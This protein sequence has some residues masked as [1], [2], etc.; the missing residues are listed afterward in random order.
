MPFPLTLSAQ[1]CLPADGRALLIGRAWVPTENGPS[2]VAVRGPEAVDLTPS[3]P[4]VSQLLNTAGPAEVRAAIR[5]APSLGAIE[6]L[7]GNSVE[8]RR[9]P[10][11]P[12]LLA[13]CDLHTV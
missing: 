3:F 6:D 1:A 8:G 2:V 4:T 5:A 7:I 10:A 9:D 11:K 13:P 12:W